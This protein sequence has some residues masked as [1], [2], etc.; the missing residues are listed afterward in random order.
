M[1]DG[2][3]TFEYR[4]ADGCAY[5]SAQFEVE[6]YPHNYAGTDG[7]KS[8][9]RKQPF[10]LLSTLGGLVNHGGKWYN[11]DGST[12]TNGNVLTGE[13]QNQGTYQYMYV[14]DNSVC[15]ADT[16]YVIITATGCDYTGIEEMD[17]QSLKVFPNPASEKVFMTWEEGVFINKI[18]LLDF[19]GRLINTLEIEEGKINGEMELNNLAKGMYTLRLSNKDGFVSRRLSIE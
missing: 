6:V 2:Q 11:P 19:S 15:P 12:R 17:V 5:D 9:C 10:S 7:T 1:Q 14:V 8:I 4:V 18:E 16:S 13:I 3:Y